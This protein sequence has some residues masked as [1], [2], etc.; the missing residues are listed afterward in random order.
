V[1]QL[2]KYENNR[3][4]NEAEANAISKKIDAPYLKGFIG[5]TGTQT[6]EF[7]PNSSINTFRSAMGMN[8]QGTETVRVSMYGNRYPFEKAFDLF[9]AV[10][11]YGAQMIR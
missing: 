2:T 7:N 1:D 4:M 10:N 3:E 11:G 5:I 8:M 6:S 9:G